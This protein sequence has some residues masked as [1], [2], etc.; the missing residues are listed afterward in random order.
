MS[1][2]VADGADELRVLRAEAD[3]AAVED[4]R[5]GL[6]APAL[7]DQAIEHLRLLLVDLNDHGALSHRGAILD[8]GPW[9]RSGLGLVEWPFRGRRPG[10]RA[11]RPAPQRRAGARAAPAPCARS[12]TRR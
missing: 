11:R 7:G 6:A 12:A 9:T 8:P 5:G 1:P 2:L 4:L 3:E 10:G